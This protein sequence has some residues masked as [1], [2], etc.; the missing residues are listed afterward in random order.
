MGY[1]L[2]V[3]SFGYISWVY[4]VC[5]ANCNVRMNVNGSVF[6]VCNVGSMVVLSMDL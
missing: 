2:V 1:M 5:G 4:L 6:M 3:E